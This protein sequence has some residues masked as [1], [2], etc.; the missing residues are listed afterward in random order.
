MFQLYRG[1]QFYWWRKPEYIEK[2][3]ELDH[4]MLHWAH[5][6]WVGFELT[7]VVIGTDCTGSLEIHLQYGHSHDS[8]TGWQELPIRGHI[9]VGNKCQEFQIYSHTPSIYC[10]YTL[11]LGLHL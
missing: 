5:L 4:I 8:P 9:N 7:L 1:G 10:L 3:T 6:A 11:C 2:T